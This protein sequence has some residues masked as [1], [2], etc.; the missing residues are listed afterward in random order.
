MS[1]QKTVSRAALDRVRNPRT[2]RGTR[3]WPERPLVCS[4]TGEDTGPVPS[5]SFHHTSTSKGDGFTIELFPLHEPHWTAIRVL[6]EEA[7]VI[8]KEF[9]LE[10][11]A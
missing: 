10:E 6:Y 9:K 1:Q 11:D 5:I 4:H 3:Y 7:L 8:R 2:H